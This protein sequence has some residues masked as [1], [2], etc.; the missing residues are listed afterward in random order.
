MECW[1]ISP[2][3]GLLSPALSAAVEPWCT[4]VVTGK[5]AVPRL[6]MVTARL[7]MDHCV[8]ALAMCKRHKLRWGH[9]LGWGADVGMLCLRCLQ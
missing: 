3:G 9:L 4:A 7:V 8:Y 2:P 1:A 6:S 5:D